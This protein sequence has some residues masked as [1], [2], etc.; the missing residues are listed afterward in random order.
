MATCVHELQ[1][2]FNQFL[3]SAP[4]KFTLQPYKADK[5]FGLLL[6]EK[7]AD[8]FKNMLC[9]FANK[10]TNLGTNYKHETLIIN[11]CNLMGE[12]EYSYYTASSL[13]N[14]LERITNTLYSIIIPDGIKF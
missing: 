7:T 5:Y 4:K 9:E 10:V 12:F 1:S 3:P 6:D 14:I 8:W 11:G 2:T 13:R